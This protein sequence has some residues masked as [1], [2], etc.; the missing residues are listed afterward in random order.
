M[1][2]A[3]D[4]RSFL[5]LEEKADLILF[6]CGELYQKKHETKGT[7]TDVGIETCSQ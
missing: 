4:N 2:V 7:V 6:N 1:I 3:L 5:L